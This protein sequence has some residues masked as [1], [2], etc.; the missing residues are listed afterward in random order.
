M[1]RVWGVKLSIVLLAAVPMMVACSDDAGGIDFDFGCPGSLDADA[2]DTEVLAWA[3][4]GMTEA[5]QSEI[6]VG[7]EEDPDSTFVGVMS[8]V[9]SQGE[10]ILGPTEFFEFMDRK[11]GVE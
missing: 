7:Y 11:C 9:E 10:S 6:C 4:C 5:Q 1:R 8:V 2:T 3:V